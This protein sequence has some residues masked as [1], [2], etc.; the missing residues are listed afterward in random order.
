MKHGVWEIVEGTEVAPNGVAALSKFNDRR[1]R[2]L[3]LLVLSLDPSQLYLLGSE[4]QDPVVVWKQLCDQYQKK[5][6]SNKLVLRR[7]LLSL[8]P[9]ENESIQT[10]IKAMMETFDAL[11]VIGEAVE[12]EDRVVYVLAS[13]PEKYNMLVT[14]LEACPE[15]PKLEIVTEKLLN[16]ERKMKEKQ[17]NISQGS[18]YNSGNHDALFVNSQ[19]KSNN[20]FYCGKPGHKIRF[21]EQK[22]RDEDEKEK[23]NN[24]HAVANFASVRNQREKYESDSSGD[25]CIALVSEA[26]NENK[27]KWV[28][29]SAATNHMCKD[30]NEMTNL[31]RL[32]NVKRVK[33][34][35]GD[36]VEA[37][38][39]GS[40]K[41]KV[42][43]GKKLRT[44]KLFNVL[45]VPGMKYNLLSIPK[46]S[47]ADKVVQFDKFGCE[48]KDPSSGE[49]LGAASKVG[50]LYYVN[51]VETTKNPRKE[52]ANIRSEITRKENV[53]RNDNRSEN[54]RKE[55]VKRNDMEKAI[56]SIRQNN[57]EQN[58]MR[59][60]RLMEEDKTT[61]NQRLN[62][63]EEDLSCHTFIKEDNADQI[64]EDEQISVTAKVQKIDLKT[65]E[66]DNIQEDID[67]KCSGAGGVEI[68]KKKNKKIKSDDVNKAKVQGK[69]KRKFEAFKR[70]CSK[71]V[72]RHNESVKDVH[73]GGLLEI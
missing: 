46:V 66:S 16:E 52:N 54:T 13:L 30:R 21:C 42:K 53:R 7:K 61:M 58:M 28:M 41:L 25:E 64:Q 62:A 26:C 2:A 43:H 5:T 47:Q 45:F 14:A 51:V 55:I 15:V 12:E 1:D 50:N 60:L 65:K 34:G 3:S 72:T 70:S 38:F 19:S 4:P 23:E 44:F 31:K 48:I 71:L 63:V 36:Y 35:N 11:S 10:H 49:V 9:N 56:E 39:E 22:K 20:C 69:F 33:V 68:N 73:R 57:F 18:L 17:E 40:V 32:D 67:W 6:W 59:R 27:S 24:R 37:R 8:K 29:D